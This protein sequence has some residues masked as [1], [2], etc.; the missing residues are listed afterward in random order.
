MRVSRSPSCCSW[1]AA[2]LLSTALAC[3]DEP[4]A[5]EPSPARLVVAWDPLAC[6]RPHRVAVDLEDEAGA[7]CSVTV[8]CNLGGVAVDVPHRGVYWF[9]AASVDAPPRSVIP[10]EVVIDEPI[11]HRFIATPR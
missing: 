4:L 2:G 10:V 9:H 11:V 8:P 3:V 7:W 1:L 6:G 5:T